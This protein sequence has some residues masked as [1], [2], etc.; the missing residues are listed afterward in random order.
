MSIIRNELPKDYYQ[1]YLKKLEAI[2]K[3]DVLEI[4]QKYFLPKKCNIVVVGSEDVL[5][6]L[7][8]FDADGQIEKLAFRSDRQHRILSV[9][10]KH[11]HYQLQQCCIF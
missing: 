9:Y 10:P 6:K 5:D 1:T 11:L 3:D 2:T 4:A 8:V 7:T